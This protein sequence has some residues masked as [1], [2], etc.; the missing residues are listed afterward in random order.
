MVFL[1][2]MADLMGEH[3]CQLAFVLQRPVETLRDKDVA[4]R[5]CKGVEIIRLDHAEV[6]IQ[7]RTLAL[8]RDPSP[9]AVDVLLQLGVL[10][11]RRCAQDV[12]GGLA[13]DGNLFLL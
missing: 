4:P 10:H 8:A 13:S 5:R 3:A 11:Q 7:I 2:D 6:P 9:H 1:D 12:A